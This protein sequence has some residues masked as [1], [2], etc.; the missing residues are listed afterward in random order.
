[1]NEMNGHDIEDLRV[2]IC[3]SGGLSH[4]TVEESLDRGVLD[5]IADSRAQ[6]NKTI[7]TPQLEFGYE[8][9][10]FTAM[11]EMGATWKI[12]TPGFPQ[13]PGLDTSGRKYGA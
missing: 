12:L 4:F 8:P 11:R 5:A 9:V 10:D 2:G 1:M 6:G 7:S 13:P 3:A